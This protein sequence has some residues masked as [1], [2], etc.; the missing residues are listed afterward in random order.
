[1][2][3]K[4]NQQ[5]FHHIL[6]VGLIVVVVLA[7]GFAGW[8]V[9]GMNKD[10]NKTLESV[11]NADNSTSTTTTTVSTPTATPTP[12]V[13]AENYVDTLRAFCLGTDPD[14]TV[15]TIQFVENTNGKFGLCTVGSKTDEMSGAMLVTAYIDGV[16]TRV[17][18]GNGMMENSLCAE[19]KIPSTI[20]ADCIGFY[21]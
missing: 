8:Y 21:E 13:V 16:W 15:G 14:T 18:G 11:G 4:L 7:L 10:T 17:W 20:Y 19:Y 2:Y 5:G 3:K 1:M 6:M 12:A 9:Y